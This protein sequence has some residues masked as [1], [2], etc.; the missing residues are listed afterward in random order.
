[1]Q[2]FS[3]DDIKGP[4]WTTQKVTI[5]SFGTVNV[6]T[7]TSVKG[8]WMRVPVLTELMPGAQL[9]AAVVPTVTYRE[10]HPGSL[11]VPICLCN[12]STCAME[13]PTKAMV[14]QFVSAKQVPLMVHPTK[15]TKETSN[16]ASKGGSWRLWTSKVSQNC[17]SQSRNGLG[18]YCSN[19]NTHLHTV[20]WTWAKLF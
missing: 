6:C 16:K 17:L 9:P 12:L 18:S 20:T 4:V 14:G 1:M 2:K 3:L 7:S 10:L 8:H 19:G 11:R 15:T 5:L 13:I